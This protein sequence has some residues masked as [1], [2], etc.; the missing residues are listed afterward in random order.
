MG[1]HSW[2]ALESAPGRAEVRLQPRPCRPA[3]ARGAERANRAR[4]AVCAKGAVS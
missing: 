1:A 3:Q 2:A 4:E